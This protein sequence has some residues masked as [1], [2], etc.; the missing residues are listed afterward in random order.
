MSDQILQ[1]EEHGEQAG[2]ALD[3]ERLRRLFSDIV[4]DASFEVERG[5]EEL[6]EELI[7][8]GLNRMRL[9]GALTTPE[10]V[11]EA[12]VNLKRLA[13]ELV[14]EAMAAD[15]P[16]LSRERMLRLMGRICPGLWPYC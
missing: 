1:P 8:D 11:E 16:T 7:E 15:E 3:A 14:H 10:P 9:E 5:C 6:V 2:A 13:R 4:R 12:Q